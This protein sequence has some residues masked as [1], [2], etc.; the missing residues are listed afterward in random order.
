MS[1]LN[2]SVLSNFT[3]KNLLLKLKNYSNFNKSGSELVHYSGSAPPG[4]DSK[5]LESINLLKGIIDKLSKSSYEKSRDSSYNKYASSDSF[6]NLFALAKNSVT[7]SFK[8]YLLL[9]KLTTNSISQKIMN[10]TSLSRPE[11]KYPSQ[12]LS[13][14]N[15][16][17]INST[18]ANYQ[19]TKY[20]LY[21]FFMN[22]SNSSFIDYNY[23]DE[24]FKSNS[25][26]S[27]LLFG[28]A[29]FYSILIITSLTSNPLLIY[30]LLWRRKAQIKLIDIF[31]ANLSLSDLFLTIFNIPLCLIIYFSEQWPFGS[32]L[33]QIGTFSTSCSIYVNIFTMAYISIDRYFA[34]TRPL[35]SNPAYQLRKKSIL[36]DN[37]TR[38]KIYFVLTLIWII[39]IFLSFP[40]FLFSKVSSKNSVLDIDKGFN[41][42]DY[43][44]NLFNDLT[45]DDF[46]ED[47]FKK[48]IIQYPHPNMKN[49]MV[50]VNFSLQYLIPSIAILYFYGKIIYHLYLNLNVEELMEPIE[51]NETRKGKSLLANKSKSELDVSNQ[52]GASFSPLSKKSTTLDFKQID[53]KKTPKKSR[54]RIEGYNRT[55]NLK[56]SIKTMIIIIALF[57]LSWLP[58]Q[59][60]RLATTFYPI[61]V[62]Y[63]EKNLTPAEYIFRSATVMYNRTNSQ[64]LYLNSTMIEACRKNETYKECLM[65]ALKGLRESTEPGSLSYNLNTLH[66]RYVFFFCYFMAMSSVC[67]NPIVYFWMHK[68]FRIEVKD[69]FSRIFSFRQKSERERIRV[70]SMITTNNNQKSSAQNV[71]FNSTKVTKFSIL[72]KNSNTR[73]NNEKDDAKKN[74]KKRLRQPFYMSSI[75]IR[76]NRFSSLSSESTGSSSKRSEN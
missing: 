37:H 51:S 32:L 18:S 54:M 1:L 30:V 49:I 75:K 12:H 43:F 69:L 29:F 64:P 55:R 7:I 6:N 24:P 8:D 68:K 34:V 47:P 31:V 70:V 11:N 21:N 50:L 25:S 14:Y 66:N 65:N 56:K 15:Q 17:L 13:V 53:A 27:S 23:F 61:V 16:S 22:A 3:I 76:K 9:Q 63:I 4:P 72:S 33:C 58:I 38:H 71:H 73:I 46:G 19:S 40:Q 60:Y 62:D 28:I 20:P 2:D 36:V 39:S 41:K 10:S 44:D 52:C 48:C 26:S 57:L 45:G 42:T 35:I 59:L 5:L 74:R 67:Y